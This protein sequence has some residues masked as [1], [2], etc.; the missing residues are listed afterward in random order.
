METEIYV[1]TL[2]GLQF[3]VRLKTGSRNH[4]LQAECWQDYAPNIIR[5]QNARHMRQLFQHSSKVG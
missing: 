5:K 2:K 3:A 4:E 1:E